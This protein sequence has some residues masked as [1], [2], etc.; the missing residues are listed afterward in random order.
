MLDTHVCLSVCVFMCVYLCAC[1]PAHVCM[2][3]YQLRSSADRTVLILVTLKGR[4]NTRL[5]ARA[6][7][8]VSLHADFK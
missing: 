5:D 2:C 8:F 4:L 7:I 1:V 6:C 3:V